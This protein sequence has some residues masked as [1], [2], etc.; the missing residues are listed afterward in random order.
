MVEVMGKRN[1]AM[2]GA[3]N[4]LNEGSKELIVWKVGND[5]VAGIKASYSS[6]EIKYTIYSI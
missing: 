6:D 1:V 4:A 2:H 3:A 5:H